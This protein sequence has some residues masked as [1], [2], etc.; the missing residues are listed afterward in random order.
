QELSRANRISEDRG[1]GT[2]TQH[3]THT[4]HEKLLQTHK[5][6]LAEI[7]TGRIFPTPPQSRRSGNV[8]TIN[9]RNQHQSQKST[10]QELTGG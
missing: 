4:I 9:H 2:S 5:I 6:I 10:Y 8:I 7:P 1:Q 3:T